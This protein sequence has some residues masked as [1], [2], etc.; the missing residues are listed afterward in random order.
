M[1]CKASITSILALVIGKAQVVFD[2][3]YICT[4]GNN[5]MRCL[6]V[7][8][9][10]FVN[11]CSFKPSNSP[12][13]HV[14]NLP[15]LPISVSTRS[16]IGGGGLVCIFRNNADNPIL[17][18]ITAYN[19]TLNKVKEFVITIP[20]QSS[21]EHGWAEGWN[22]VLG[23]KITINHADYKSATYDLK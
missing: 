15:D 23:D 3:Y 10:I 14:N 6:V 18:K 16:S 19:K 8:F 2:F 4:I 13:N 20:A 9:L 5:K 21:F 1:Y 12:D 7:S 22:Y 17:V 11:G